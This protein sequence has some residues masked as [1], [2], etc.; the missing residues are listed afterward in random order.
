MPAG[1]KEGPSQSWT[2]EKLP[3]ILEIHKYSQGGYVVI[4]KEQTAS[5]IA[6]PTIVADLP[7]A[8]KKQARKYAVAFQEKNTARVDPE[9]K[10]AEQVMYN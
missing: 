2:H 8:N 3:Y 1:S 10:P 6:V 9:R 5:G 4:L 7:R